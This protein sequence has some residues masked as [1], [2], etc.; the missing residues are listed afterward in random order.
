MFFFELTEISVTSTIKYLVGVLCLSGCSA[1]S[2]YVWCLVFHPEACACW[3]ITLQLR[4]LPWGDQ[5][6]WEGEPLGKLRSVALSLFWLCLVAEFP[7]Q[8]PGLKA[9]GPSHLWGLKASK[10]CFPPHHPCSLDQKSSCR[11]EGAG[12]LWCRG[13]W[14]ANWDFHARQFLWKFCVCFVCKSFVLLCIWAFLH[15]PKLAE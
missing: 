2:F 3:F 15:C 14:P 8:A 9:E 6:A 1:L 10:L 13:Y 11:G 12:L 7:P 5:P 4:A